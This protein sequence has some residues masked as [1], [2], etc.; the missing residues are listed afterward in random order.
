MIKAGSENV[1]DI[2][3]TLP[4][5]NAIQSSGIKSQDVNLNITPPTPSIVYNESTVYNNLE[6]K[7]IVSGLESTFKSTQQSGV[8]LSN[9]D[10]LNIRKLQP[11]AIV[12]ESVSGITTGVAGA[13]TQF[14]NFYSFGNE[15]FKLSRNIVASPISSVQ[16]FAEKEGEL[17]VA[18]KI[19]NAFGVNI[20][21]LIIASG[22]DILLSGVSNQVS[23][24][25]DIITT[26][27][28]QVNNVSS[29]EVYR[30]IAKELVTELTPRSGISEFIEAKIVDIST[31]VK[32]ESLGIPESGNL[33]PSDAIIAT[34]IA[35]NITYIR[36][37]I[38]DSQDRGNVVE[39]AS[40]IINILDTLDITQPSG[41]IASG[42]QS[43]V[44]TEIATELG[45]GYIPL[46]YL[47][48]APE[49]LTISVIEQITT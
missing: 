41:N 44:E 47:P 14:K 1:S 16:Y 29:E 36:D 24:D 43:T 9:A 45:S 31:N 21:E 10:L 12:V 13:I 23:K 25:L 8:A 17:D 5:G 38:N 19:Q 48:S 49:N 11:E 2:V 35:D 34:N 3:I 42:I 32:K 28:T 4:D 6:I 15:K 30:N 26:V 20:D 27:L 46:A 39:V 7:V 18:T 22:N 37:A 40:V 33:D